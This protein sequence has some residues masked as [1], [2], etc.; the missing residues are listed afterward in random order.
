M[1]RIGKDDFTP[2]QLADRNTES[3]KRNCEPN[4]S[5]LASGVRKKEA[6]SSLD[7]RDCCRGE[8]VF[9]HSGICKADI[10]IHLRLVI[11]PENGRN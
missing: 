4:A 5:P 7:L 11:S 9:M 3:R 2:S 6:L 1:L 8:R 10:N